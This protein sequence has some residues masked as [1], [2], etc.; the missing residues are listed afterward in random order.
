MET[1]AEKI[2]RTSNHRFQLKSEFKGRSQPVTLY[3]IIHN[4]EFTV[5]GDAAGRDPIRCNC[6]QCSK[7]LKQK[8][9]ANAHTEVVCAYC[10]KHFTLANS[11]LSG[12]KSGL[13]FCCREHKDL[14]QRIESGNQFDIMRPSHYGIDNASTNYR[15]IAFENYAHKCA[16]CGWAE[17]EDILQVH[18]ID[19]NR[20]NAALN[21][22]IILCPTC[23]W[24]LTTGKYKLLGRTKIIKL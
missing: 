22:L 23:H 11:K 10:G 12:S 13:Y 24:K 16:I 2:W 7:E 9:Y 21:N 18:H 20:K 3:C 17:D 4:L 8:K 6:P 14:A 1:I 15:K 5:S 19:S